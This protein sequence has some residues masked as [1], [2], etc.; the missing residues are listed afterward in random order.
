MAEWDGNESSCSCNC[1]FDIPKGGTLGC[2]SL[3]TPLSIES[4]GT[5]ET[6]VDGVLTSLGLLKIQAGDI[7]AMGNTA[8]GAYQDGSVEFWT[9][10]TAPPVV[11][12]GFNSSS[13]SG[14]FGCCSVSTVNITANGFTFRFFNGDSS[15]RNP[16]FQW[17]AAGI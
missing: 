10:F 16:A 5:G 12:I 4:G 3:E 17:I 14:A 1:G 13:T 9:P 7:P 8:G 6:T 2:L 15:A 11:V